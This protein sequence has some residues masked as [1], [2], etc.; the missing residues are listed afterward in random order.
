MDMKKRV[1]FLTQKKSCKSQTTIFI[2][3]A[4]LIIFGITIFFIFRNYS[5]K[6]ELDYIKKYGEKPSIDSI[7][8]FILDCHKETSKK[9]LEIIGIQGGYYNKP[10]YYF[11]MSWAFIPYYYYEG[12]L[13]MPS[14][15]AIEKELSYYIDDKIISC[16]TRIKF[17]SFRIGYKQPSTKTTIKETAVVFSTNQKFEIE[18]ENS[19]VNFELGKYP[20]TLNSSLNEI[21]EISDYITN[22][23]KENPDLMCINCIAELAKEKNIYVDFISIDEDTT[24]VMLI[25]N[26]TMETPYIFEFM[27]KYK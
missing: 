4:A 27:N 9:A 8:D 10:E 22:S 14:K 24:L 17:P 13:L 2:I 12:D 7:Q 23:H 21:V 15:E 5:Q 3:I 11:N 6:E 19:V 25:E 18:H 1:G 26:R 20:L 16:I